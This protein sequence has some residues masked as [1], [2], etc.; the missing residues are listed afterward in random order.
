VLKKTD[1]GGLF[2]VDDTPAAL[3]DAAARL[4]ARAVVVTG[5]M[6]GHKVMSPPPGTASAA[7]EDALLAAEGIDAAAFKVLGKL[8]EGTRRPLLVPVGTPSVRAGD[9]PDSLVL[10]LTL[11]P[12]AYATVLLAEVTK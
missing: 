12:G 9:T 11:P 6:Y 4:A 8:A 2:T 3:A 1:T 10:E 5:P 7:R